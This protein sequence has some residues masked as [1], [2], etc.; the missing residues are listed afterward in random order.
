MKS[1]SLH[2]LY[3]ST[4]CYLTYSHPCLGLATTLDRLPLSTILIRLVA[5]RSLDS[6]IT[7]IPAG[8]SP[9]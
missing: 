8:P 1:G 9:L 5:S 4:Q 2:R 3:G 7:H 6:V